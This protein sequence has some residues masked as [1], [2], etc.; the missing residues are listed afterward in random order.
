MAVK[1][2]YYEVLGVGRG[3]TLEEIKRSYR[4]L[5]REYHPDVNK[6]GE[7]EERFK[8]IA[9]AYSVLS[10]SDKRSRYDRF[11]AEGLNGGADFSGFGAM[12]MGDLLNQFFGGGARTGRSAAERGADLRYDLQI[13]LEEAA[14]G[15]EK[16][17]EVPRL[18]MCATCEG[19]GASPGTTAET[20]P[21]CQGSGQLRHTQQ[22]I[23]G[24]FSS[25]TPCAHCGATGRIVR[26]PCASC[27]GDGR[28]MTEDEVVV[29]IPSGIEDGTRIQVRGEGESGQRGGPT[30]DLY[31]YV[32]I[33]EHE[34][35]ER[36]G[37]ELYTEVPISFAQAALG[38]RITVQ[39]LFG[40]DELHIPAGTQ[41][42]TRFRVA[43]AGMPGLHNRGRGDLHVMARVVTPTSLSDEQKDLLRQFAE[44]EP[45][46][47]EDK[48]FFERLKERLVGD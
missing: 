38:D 35:F 36:R 47:D 19:S 43:G 45:N 29:R 48:G 16:T 40:E 15:V 2:D 44:H 21:Y 12:D 42:G 32:F 37:R 46:R 10:D 1:R 3:A 27:G 34:R 22:T 39:T 28:V 24:S 7:A 20:C 26:D 5:A 31:V 9:E 25:V 30:G 11:G 13:T 6:A 8:E 17:I 18:R 23:L 4:R 41:T 33:Q 14:T